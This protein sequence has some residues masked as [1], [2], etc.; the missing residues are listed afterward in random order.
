[1]VN[2]VDDSEGDIYE[3]WESLREDHTHLLTSDC[4][5]SNLVGGARLFAALAELTEEHG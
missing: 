5:D 3:K 4:G 1:M 2:I